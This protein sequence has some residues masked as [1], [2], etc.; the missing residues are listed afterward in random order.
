MTRVY[1]EVCRPNT[2]PDGR[3]LLTASDPQR[4]RAAARHLLSNEINGVDS[5]DPLIRMKGAISAHGM[6]TY[7]VRSRVDILLAIAGPALLGLARSRCA[8]DIDG[9]RRND[10]FH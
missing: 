1:A 10:P 8:K 5:S 7:H 2:T 3:R 6:E 4:T 9:W